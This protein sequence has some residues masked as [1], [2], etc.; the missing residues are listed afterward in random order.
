[1][2]KDE[3]C[4][5]IMEVFKLI[6]QKTSSKEIKNI[7]NVTIKKKIRSQISN[8]SPKRKIEKNKDKP[9]NLAL[10]RNNLIKSK[11]KD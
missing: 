5:Y 6:D 2:P 7:I 3:I 9:I 1:M 11:K 10:L 8:N 4:N